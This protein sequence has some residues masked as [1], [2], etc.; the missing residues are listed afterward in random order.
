[1]FGGPPEN[2]RKSRDRLSSLFITLSFLYS[3]SLSSLSNLLRHCLIATLK[4]SYLSKMAAVPG[5]HSYQ[6]FL[7]RIDTIAT[8]WGLNELHND[9]TWSTTSWSD[10]WKATFTETHWPS[11]GPNGW[12]HVEEVLNASRRMQGVD[13]YDRWFVSSRFTPPL[14]NQR[15]SSLLCA[16][17]G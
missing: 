9:G 16:A 13:I 14:A 4:S 15:S 3:L 2:G 6:D 1:M 5:Q 10:H 11:G 7:D 17:V 8:K 12:Q